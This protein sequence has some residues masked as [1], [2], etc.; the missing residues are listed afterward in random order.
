[1]KT[2]AFAFLLFATAAI[3]IDTTKI[4]DGQTETFRSGSRTVRVHK[5]GNTTTVRVQEGDRLDTITIRRDG[6]H[7][8]FGTSNNGAPRR[9]IALDRPEVIVDGMD[10]ETHLTNKFGE[11]SSS[12]VPVVP[13]PPPQ[14]RHDAPSNYFYCPKDGAMLVVPHTDGSK[15]Y[16]CPVDGTE[17][18]GG[19]GTG[20]RYYLLAPDK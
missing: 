20:R 11:G 14:R 1:M 3:R 8:L 9:M 12:S 2:L 17:M 16:R 15:T 5:A 18:K 19:V 13:M 7:V 6:K 4:A 10:L